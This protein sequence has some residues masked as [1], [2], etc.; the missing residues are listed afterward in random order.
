MILLQNGVV[1]DGSGQP[2][3]QVEVLVGDTH[4]EAVG[5]IAAGPDME[6]VDCS[7]LAIAPGF[8]DVHSHADLV[9]CRRDSFTKSFDFRED[10]IGRSRPHER[11]CVG[12]P[13]GGVAFDA[14]DEL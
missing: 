11:V 10:G 14:L 13:L 7:G 9:S 12:V 8:I 6:V 3:K 2:A 1:I 4:I 5:A